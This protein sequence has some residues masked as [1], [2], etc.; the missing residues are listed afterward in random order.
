MVT[1]FAL[2]A[3]VPRHDDVARRPL[4]ERFQVQHGSC[5][6]VHQ[7]PTRPSG[8]RDL[9]DGKSVAVPEWNLL[10]ADGSRGGDRGK[11]NRERMEKPD[12]PAT[13]HGRT[14][15]REDSI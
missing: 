2:V 12:E 9:N 15:G 1:S 3:S 6:R 11:K 4:R 5:R 13:I 8:S 14:S 7:E 10:C